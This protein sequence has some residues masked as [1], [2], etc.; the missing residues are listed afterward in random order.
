MKP[1]SKKLT[2]LHYFGYFSLIN[3]ARLYLLIGQ[4]TEALKYIENFNLEVVE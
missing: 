2:N 4:G 1:V 3:L